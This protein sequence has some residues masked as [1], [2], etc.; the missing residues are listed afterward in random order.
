MTMDRRGEEP[1]F[2]RPWLSVASRPLGELT[3]K[4]QKRHDPVTLFQRH[5]APIFKKIIFTELADSGQALCFYV[6]PYPKLGTFL[7][8][9]GEG[10]GWKC[11]IAIVTRAVHF[12]TLQD[13]R[14][15]VL[16]GTVLVNIC[17]I[18]SLRFRNR[19]SSSDSTSGTLIAVGLFGSRV[20]GT[21][22]FVIFKMS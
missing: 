19:S 3:Q 8:K 20:A 2:L 7:Q 10:K 21:S 9:L 12:L 22:G 17:W 15:H 13:S 11:A 5:Q 16:F 6:A 14:P 1:R 4:A 18:S